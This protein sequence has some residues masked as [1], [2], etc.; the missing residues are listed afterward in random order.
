MIRVQEGQYRDGFI[1]RVR[2][3]AAWCAALGACS[4]YQSRLRALIFALDTHDWP[5]IRTYMETGQFPEPIQ[6]T[7]S[8]SR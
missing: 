8:A 1:R 2:D 5:V 4:T 7:S 6:R 3:E